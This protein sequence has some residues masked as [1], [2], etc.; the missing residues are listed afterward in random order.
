MHILLSNDDG[1]LAPGLRIL[2]HH[3]CRIASVTV[4]APE[5]NRS[6]A[7]SSLTLDRPLRLRKVE[8]DVYAVDGTP[9][10][11]V[12]LAITEIFKQ[13]P[14][15]V[16]AG[17]NAGE[18]LGED[19]WYSGTVA[20]AMEGCLMGAPALAASLIRTDNDEDYSAAAMIV[21]DLVERVIAQ[22]M[23]KG[24]LLN[25]NIPINSRG[26][27][28]TR[29]GQRHREASSVVQTDPRGQ[30]VYWIGPVGPPGRDAGPGTDFHAIAN[31]YVSITPLQTD[32]TA[33]TQLEE[34]G[35]WIAGAC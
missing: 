20:A 27:L 8:D 12:H 34:V 31:Q 18:N 14:T 32:L 30:P 2:R 29:L 10:D 19:V 25:V 17:I 11:C 13:P 3:L 6:G 15:M 35:Q 1:Y 24:W 9:A 28:V 4:I 26:T 22:G 21:C 33:Y 7:S 16:L 5:Q 23:P